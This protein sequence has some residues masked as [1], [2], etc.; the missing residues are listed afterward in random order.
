MP[1]RRSGTTGRSIG[2]R[3]CDQQTRP[4]TNTRLG[5]R[6]SR[7]LPRLVEGLSRTVI[8]RDEANG[9]FWARGLPGGCLCDR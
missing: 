1:G 8:K 6:L 3:W 2:L 9:G 4:A 5:D 7:Q